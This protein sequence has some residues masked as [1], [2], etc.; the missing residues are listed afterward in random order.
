MLTGDSMQAPQSKSQLIDEALQ[1]TLSKIEPSSH[2]NAET[3]F[4][5]FYANFDH[6]D[7]KLFNVNSLSHTFL[8]LWDLLQVREKDQ[9]KYRLYRW[10]PGRH[11]QET[12]RLIID[13]VNRNMPFSVDS[14]IGLL[15]R[16]ELAAH[17]LLHPVICVERNKANKLVEILPVSGAKSDGKTYESIIHCEIKAS[18]SSE[19]IAK[20][21]QEIPQILKDINFATSDWQTMRQ[22]TFEVVDYVSK[23]SHRDKAEVIEFLKWLED[24]HFT[25]LGYCEFSFEDQSKPY[26]EVIEGSQLG[27]AKNKSFQDLPSIF[28]GLDT[29]PDGMKY[30]LAPNIFM[31]NKSSNFSTVHR[32]TPM[33]TLGIR[34]VNEKGRVTKMHLFLGLFTSEA[35]DSSSRDIPLLR[36]K[37]QHI[38]SRS[39]F[40]K[41]WHDGKALIHIL[42]SLP[43]D[44]LFQTDEEE[45]TEI[46]L[47]ILEIQSRKRLAMFLRK[48]QFS[49][50]LSCLV[51][52]PRDRFDYD[53]C[54]EIRLILEQD[55]NSKV[56][57]IKAQFGSFAL[58]LVHYRIDLSSESNMKFNQGLLE[59]KL[60]EAARS[61]KDTFRMVLET[62]LNEWESQ[63]LYNKY[64]QAFTKSYEERFD[65]HEAFIDIKYF[66]KVLPT[67]ERE[68]YV[69]RPRG[70][71]DTKLKL[72]L[73][74]PNRALSLS[75]ILP[76]LENLD[77]KVISEI[78][79]K[80]SPEGS[81]T[82]LW[83]QDF[84][85]ESRGQ[86]SIDLQIARTKFIDTLKKIWNGETDD[87][88]FNRLVL[89]SGLEW[90]QC[91][92]LLA[93]S[94]YLRQIGSH[95]SENYMATILIQ[96]PG[97]TRLISELFVARFS[98]SSHDPQT[99][100]RILKAIDQTFVH[101]E[102]PDDD[103]ILRH[104]LNLVRSTIRTNYFQP[105][106]DGLPKTY[107]SFKFDSSRVEDMPLPKPMYEI[108]VFS[109]HMEA[110][111]LRGGKVARGGIRWSDRM[112]DYRIEILGLMKAQ[113]VKNTVIVPVGSK[114]G[115]IVK[116]NLNG[117][118]REDQMKHV[119][120][121][122]KTMMC[123]LLDIT[124][125]IVNGK[126]IPPQD[127]V[128]HD[129]NDP[130]L[131]V[132]ADKGTATFSDYANEISSEYNFWLKDAFA[133]GGSAGYDHKKM[134]ITARGAWESVRQHFRALDINVDKESVTCVGVGDMS[135]DVFGN[136]MLLSEPLKLVAAFNHMHIFVDPDPNPETSYKERQRL[137][138]LS[139]SSWMDYDPKL[140]SKGGGIFDRKAKS[141]TVTPEIQS[142]LNI[143][144]TE[145]TPNELIL[146]ILKASV[147]LIWFGGIGTYVKSK[148]ESHSD[149]GDRINDSL[150]INGAELNAKVIGE[151]ANLAVTQ[152]GRIEFARAGGRI[153]TDAIDNSAGV[154]CSDHEVNIK[155]L[156]NQ[157]VDDKKITLEQRNKVLEE[158]TDNVARLVLRDNQLQNQ[159]I[160]LICSQGMGLADQ[161]AILMRSLEKQGLLNR[162]LEYLPDDATLAEYQKANIS[163]TR[164]EIAVLLSYGKIK[165][166][167]D[168]LE[169]DLIDHPY[170]ES[171]LV[172]YFPDLIQQRYRD[173]IPKHPLIREIIATIAVNTI[174]NRMGA[175]F[176]NEM[177]EKTAA[178]AAEVLKAYFI[179]QEIFGLRELW[180]R[181]ENLHE[182]IGAKNQLSVKVSIWR[183]VRRGVLWL[184]R[185]HQDELDLVKTTQMF[186]KGIGE[187]ETCLQGTLDEGSLQNLHTGI[188]SYL[189]LGLAED[190]A[191]RLGSLGLMAS[192]PDIVLIA[193]ESGYPVKEAASI[194]FLCGDKFGFN[195]LRQAIDQLKSNSS[196]HRLALMSM[197]E[198]LYNHQSELAVQVLNHGKVKKMQLQGKG[199]NIVK[200][201][202]KFNKRP[203]QRIEN[204]LTEIMSG[205]TVDFAQLAVMSRELRILSSI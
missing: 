125:N 196:W 140:L 98:P 129:D 27:I 192:F 119:V 20:L 174:L 67:K 75:E 61:W 108:F 175:S 10:K 111:H 172:S 45:L 142:L 165:L 95:F 120:S 60:I 25:F 159:A 26:G 200:D 36:H 133:S 49:R 91:V 30:L 88:P 21:E 199:E 74:S 89:R 173:Y 161:Q 4:R 81:E 112:E 147:D 65:A 204:F 44:E 62:Q 171:R 114:G 97:I 156:M 106:Q 85:M 151:G 58:A 68:A 80:V 29:N 186:Q 164:P 22:K 83:V 139:K 1:S 155:I 122:Y 24:E 17:I 160:S 131:V 194:Y 46:G 141:I 183:L 163:L 124:D 189:D 9:A 63:S 167:N 93:Y 188:K 117:L 39:G 123:G 57:L 76:T 12:E 92:L 59:Q 38:V 73:Y 100:S 6:E 42:D 118:P 84:E 18:V 144:Q 181:A 126:V 193:N 135:G 37:V 48:D 7:T 195:Y 180:Y 198:D 134:A 66:E 110:I 28:K 41:E 113:M 51:Y 197:T 201:W 35:Y 87:D 54:E 102:N 176:V 104:F 168:I 78:P 43:R 127:V 69:Y 177:S 77:L 137:F 148:F 132:A 169:S 23:T 90:R 19:Q 13:I 190:F 128:C 145:I 56:T 70:Y 116:K 146:A 107:I 47:A 99:E 52:I 14:L 205:G 16:H 158:M 103:R 157:L 136:G 130:Y 166:Y 3:L 184:L 15:E 121:C 178:S 170:F 203:S 182:Q 33:D 31:I 138:Q 179:V 53:L 5:Q 79:F 153:N 32:S 40:D 105:S 82:S 191:I 96:N 115:F 50:F 2:Q 8:S 55:L 187:L 94:R 86:C 109:P 152:L 154:D 64:S 72:K 101:V 71:E 185:S 34:Q 11:E 162:E 202:V 149:V 143:D 150:R